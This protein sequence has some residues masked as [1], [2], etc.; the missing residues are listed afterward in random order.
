MK[1]RCTISL[2]MLERILEDLANMIMYADDGML[3]R[4]DPE[5]ADFFARVDKAQETLDKLNEKYLKIV[6]K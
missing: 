1:K 2:E 5:F 6:R 4:Y 3:D